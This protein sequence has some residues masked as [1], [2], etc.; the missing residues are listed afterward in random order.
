MRIDSNGLLVIQMHE[1]PPAPS[2]QLSDRAVQYSTVS[3]CATFHKVIH[4]LNYLCPYD[5]MVKDN[6]SAGGL[7]AAAS[8][9]FGG[10]AAG[11]TKA[12][13]PYLPPVFVRG[14]GTGRRGGDLEALRCRDQ[15]SDRLG[16]LKIAKRE[17]VSPVSWLIYTNMFTVFYSA[18]QFHWSEG[19]LMCEK[20]KTGKNKKYQT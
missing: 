6:I 16:A 13:T 5:L 2:L 14:T 17:S 15:E 18:V 8:S 4:H 20:K 12:V 10:S 3:E 19:A 1:F 9:F 7:G 11:I